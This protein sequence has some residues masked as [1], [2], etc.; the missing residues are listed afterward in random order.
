MENININGQEYSPVPNAGEENVLNLVMYKGQWYKP[1]EKRKKDWKVVKSDYI[2]PVS[3]GHYSFEDSI[4]DE[5]WKI[6][7]IEYKG[8]VFT[9]GDKTENGKITGFEINQYRDTM[10]SVMSDGELKGLRTPIGIVK[11]VIEKPVLFTTEDQQPVYTG[12]EIHYV[13]KNTFLLGTIK[14]SDTYMTF[15]ETSEYSHAVKNNCLYFKEKAKAQEY[16]D[17]N[18]KKFSKNDIIKALKE[19]SA[20]WGAISLC[21]SHREFNEKLGI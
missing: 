7:A 20:N 12:E 4:K 19:S 13:N 1:I 8:E 16:I 15:R 2:G 14:V 18:E 21:I 17:L 3:N 6:T 5:N 9:I 10:L 11:K